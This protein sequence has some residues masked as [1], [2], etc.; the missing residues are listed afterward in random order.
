MKENFWQKLHKPFFVLAPLAN[1]TDAAFRR[2]IAHYGKPDV[3]WTEFVAADGLIRATAEGKR[4]LL[5]DLE[6]SEIER[7]IVAQLFSG[8]P[9]YMEQAAALVDSLGFDGIDINMGCPDKTVEKQNSGASLIKNPALAVELIRAAKRGAPTLPI[10]VKTR[11]GYNKVEVEEWFPALLKEDIAALTVHARTRKEMSKVPARWEFVKRA[12]EIRDEMKKDTLIIGNG[13]VATLEEGI[14]RVK[15]T[16]CEGIMIGRGIFGN[17]FVFTPTGKA[18]DL[19]T[20]LEALELHVQ[21]FDEI[22]GNTKNFTLM[23]KH[24]KSYIQNF[25]NASDLRENLMAAENAEEVTE[26]L[27]KFQAS[28]L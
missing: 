15:E 2:V 4:K 8:T 3:L 7:P 12:V 17:P 9:L 21:L 28:N 18:K 16:G 27:K 25:P 13:D 14:L 10:S 5:K 6:Y 23:K 24:F 20:Q 19:K 1:V 22:L 11:V 26:I